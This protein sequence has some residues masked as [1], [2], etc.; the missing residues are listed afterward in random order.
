MRAD[1]YVNQC[2]SSKQLSLDMDLL[3]ENLADNE[4]SIETT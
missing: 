4:Q 3:Y 1:I 2:R